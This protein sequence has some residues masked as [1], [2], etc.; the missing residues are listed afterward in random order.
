MDFWHGPINTWSPIKKVA[1]FTKK[2][3]EICWFG[4]GKIL[5]T[6]PTSFFPF[7]VVYSQ[8]GVRGEEGAVEG[9]EKGKG[10]KDCFKNTNQPKGHD[11]YLF[12]TF[13]EELNRPLVV[14]EG[15]ILYIFI[16]SH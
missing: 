16:L 11:T 13:F 7:Y 8:D 12:Q 5:L 3:M 1:I 10:A 6:L 2:K 4:E 15:R 14:K 9:R